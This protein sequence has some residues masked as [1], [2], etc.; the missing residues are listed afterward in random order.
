[1]VVFIGLVIWGTR[2]PLV[3]R[4]LSALGMGAGTGL[5]VWGILM[6]AK[7]QQPPFASPAA[8]I[9]IGAGTLAGSITLLVISFC[10]SCT[11]RKG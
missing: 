4:I 2:N 9:A 10:G 5:L 3:W 1:L 8:I 6:A 7:M 11:G